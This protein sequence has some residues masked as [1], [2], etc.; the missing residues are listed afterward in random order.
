MDIK[1]KQ[2]ILYKTLFALQEYDKVTKDSSEK[3]K[4]ANQIYDLVSFSD[5][6][7]M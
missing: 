7:Y 4:L 5:L 2:K 3:V 6:L 1:G